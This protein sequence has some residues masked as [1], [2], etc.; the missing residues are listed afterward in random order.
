MEASNGDEKSAWLAAIQAHTEYFEAS[1]ATVPALRSVQSAPSLCGGG[2]DDD[3]EGGE[4]APQMMKRTS[5]TS[6]TPSGR[7]L[8]T[9]PSRGS[10][11]S[12]V[13]D[14]KRWAIFLLPGEDLVLTGL[15]G[16]PNPVGIHLLRQLVLTSRKRL[17]YIDCKTM[18]LKG[19]IHWTPDPNAPFPSVKKVQH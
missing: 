7:S 6:Q 10:M 17:L 4:E 18:E 16:K 14:K 13:D 19:E 5:T 2:P 3:A 8:S 9:A 1:L 12:V 15:T 11:Y